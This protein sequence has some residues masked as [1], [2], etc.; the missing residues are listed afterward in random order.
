MSWWLNKPLHLGDK[1]V[2]QVTAIVGE[3][4]GI[5]QDSGIDYYLDAFK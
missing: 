2:L 1:K 3:L 5:C 4:T